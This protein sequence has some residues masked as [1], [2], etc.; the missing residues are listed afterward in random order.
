MLQRIDERLKLMHF[1]DHYASNAA[2]LGYDY[3]R[4]L[5]RAHRRGATKFRTLLDPER[6]GKL[7]TVLAT[8]SEWLMHGEQVTERVPEAA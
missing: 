4:A 3:I 5:R 8:T 1:S 7:A 2:G 6:I